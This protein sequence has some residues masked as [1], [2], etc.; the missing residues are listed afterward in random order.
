VN[1]ADIPSYVALTVTLASV[2]WDWL[3]AS[4]LRTTDRRPGGPAEPSRGDRVSGEVMGGVRKRAA[5]F[6]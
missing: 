6:H 3:V 4:G 2:A 5:R 1:A